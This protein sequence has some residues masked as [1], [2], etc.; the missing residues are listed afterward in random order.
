MSSYPTRL[1]RVLREALERLR[2]PRVLG[3]AVGVVVLVDVALRVGG[4]AGGQAPIVWDAAHYWGLAGVV[5]GG[6]LLLLA[7]GDAFRPPVYPFFLACCQ[8]LF[9]SHALLAAVVLQHLMGIATN[10]LCAWM[11]G[12]ITGS[13]L[14]ILLTAAL[15]VGFQSRAWFANALMSETLFCFSL[16]CSFVAL[17]AWLDRPDRS[18][19]ALIGIT[20]GFSILVRPVAQALW[21]LFGFV[22][23]LRAPWR[24]AGASRRGTI[25]MLALMLAG[26]ALCTGP[27]ITRNYVLFDRPFLT[28]ALGRNLWL[29]CFAKSHAEPLPIP[30]G[31]AME[32]VLQRLESSPAVT[33]AE[34]W[35]V[36]WALLQTGLSEVEADSLMLAAS[37]ETI[38]GSPGLFA[39]VVLERIP[40][41]WHIESIR[42]G[43]SPR[44]WD[45]LVGRERY[46]DGTVDLYRGQAQW[47]SER[48]DRAYESLPSAFRRPTLVQNSIFACLAFLGSIGLM[49]GPTQRALGAALAL[50][51]A[52]FCFLT[53]LVEL[54]VYRY[55][56]VIEPLML[57][58]CCAGIPALL[59]RPQASGAQP[60]AAPRDRESPGTGVLPRSGG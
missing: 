33:F 15:S 29:S 3:V 50:S 21:I 17:F 60:P 35:Q 57:V 47:R 2:Q 20:L 28:S 31:K 40:R 39:A 1:R 22:M 6:D 54:P 8:L 16:M 4:S 9:G 36:H 19:A 11:V 12:R 27:W 59:Q 25:A 37:V 34:T 49:L 41:Y 24:E 42:A 52:Y 5:S 13:R 7:G 56:A 30:E 55:R 48:W 45:V 18:R 10:L 53:C 44:S 43:L 51:F 14:M 46:A 23:L 32:E 26:I 58:A 38:R